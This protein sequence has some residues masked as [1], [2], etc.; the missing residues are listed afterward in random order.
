MS[1]V[2]GCYRGGCGGKGCH[3]SPRKAASA[4]IASSSPLMRSP[5]LSTNQPLPVGCGY[6]LAG[7]VLPVWELEVWASEEAAWVSV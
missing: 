2:L 1:S 5:L 3:T 7:G 4:S 6:T